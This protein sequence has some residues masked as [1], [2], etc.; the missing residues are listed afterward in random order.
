MPMY[1]YTPAVPQDNQQKNV[2][3]PIMQDNFQAIN[4]LIT[5][6]HVGF[7]T[8]DFGK[9]N[10]VQMPVQSGMQFSVPSGI[11]LLA[12]ETLMYNLAYT[13]SNQNETWLTV[14]SSN[15]A[16]QIPFTASIF[17]RNGTPPNVS[18]VGSGWCYLPSGLIMKWGTFNASASNP[19]VFPTGAGIP[20]FANDTLSFQ[21][22]VVNTGTPYGCVI[23]CFNITKI[24]FNWA[25]TN[26]P[27]SASFSYLAMGY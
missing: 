22:S 2:S 14:N 19:Y 1:F 24:G 25:I 12:G 4:E 11:T 26:N 17:G 20:V 16:Y 9:H 18:T 5:Q 10:A 27:G 7:N 3:Q 15:G 21:V 13:V 6:N 8:A 23:N